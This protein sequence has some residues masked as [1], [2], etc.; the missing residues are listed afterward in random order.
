MLLKIISYFSLVSISYMLQR[1]MLCAI[2]VLH[3]TGHTFHSCSLLLKL[4]MCLDFKF[5][6]FNMMEILVLKSSCNY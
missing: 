4:H 1:H 2:E 3:S 5:S 6:T